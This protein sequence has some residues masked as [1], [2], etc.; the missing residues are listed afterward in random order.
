MSSFPSFLSP[1]L[2]L[3]PLPKSSLSFADQLPSFLCAHR[4]IAYVGWMLIYLFSLPIWNFVLP[5]YSY[6][7]FDDFSWG[8]TRKIEG[9]NPKE[10][11]HGDKEGVFDSSSIVMKASSTSVS[12]LS[13][14]HRDLELTSF[15]GLAAMGR[16]REGATLEE[17]NSEPRLLLRCC[18]AI[19]VSS[20][21]REPIC[22]SLCLLL[23]LP[24][25]KLTLSSPSFLAVHGLY[26][27][28]LLRWFLRRTRLR[29]RSTL[30]VLQ[31]HN[32]ILL[33]TQLPNRRRGSLS[34]RPRPSPRT[35]RSS[36]S[37]NLR[38]GFLLPGRRR[39]IVLSKHHGSFDDLVHSRVRLFQRILQLQRT[40]PRSIPT[41]SAAS[42]T[43]AL[44]QLL[45]KRRRSLSR[46]QRWLLAHNRSSI[47]HRLGLRRQ[48][49]ERWIVFSPEP[50]RRRRSL[51][52]G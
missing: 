50:S 10:E 31:L 49:W 14:F 17:W 34:T 18:S 38:P 22:E 43:T 13:P 26:R 35:P 46:S 40:L 42:A 1:S 24:L 20:S 8:E 21:R 16:V 23:R 28:N 33:R 25:A 36:R 6:W 15:F 32:P 3:S 44:L 37:S 52:G 27:R 39:R 51:A 30:A 11:G 12:S 5:A 2:P 48:K 7:R 9:D 41:T 45:S 19:F 4:K 29:K 47:S